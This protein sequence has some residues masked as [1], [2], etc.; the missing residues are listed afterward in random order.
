MRLATRRQLEPRQWLPDATGQLAISAPE[1]RSLS[2]AFC[3]RFQSVYDTIGPMHCP[4]GRAKSAK[5]TESFR[6]VLV[7]CPP[8]RALSLAVCCRSR[9][10][11]LGDHRSAPRPPDPPTPPTPSP[12]S[13]LHPSPYH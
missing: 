8:W 1:L 13:T 4:S 6:G 3:R 10:A 11:H 9:L 7:R 5:P 12:A 2:C